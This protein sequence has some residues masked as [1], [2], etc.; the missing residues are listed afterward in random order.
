MN[1]AEHPLAF[2]CHGDTLYGILTMPEQQA[3]RAVLIVVG[4]PQYRTGS[5]RQFVL[6]AREFASHGYPVLRFDYR[7]M[8]DSEGAPRNFEQVDE[9]IRA[10]I[11]HLFES[12]PSVR[13][14]VI[15]GLCDGASAAMFYA[16]KDARVSGL[17]LVN[18]W[19]YT[20][21][22]EAKARL[23]HYYQARMLD[24]ELWKKIARGEF[25]FGA[26][27]KSL[28]TSAG[29]ACKHIPAENDG[30]ASSRLPDRLYVAMRRF[31]GETLLL[32]SEKDLTAQEFC[33]LL[34]QSPG[35]RD[36]SARPQLL[37]HNL[38][39]ANHTFSRSGWRDE[40]AGCILRWLGT[41]PQRRPAP[42]RTRMPDR[43]VHL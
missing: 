40:V 38:A 25:N 26:A 28:W 23:K 21:E 43:Q 33:A 11:D 1:Y 24:A 19:A 8:G 7:G 39:G 6:L 12:V 16:H 2:S 34:R 20:E 9:D 18:P 15:F 29:R 13:D 30:G 37:R 31:Q 5:H 14:V 10:A 17:A 36:L 42:S 32:L 41:A 22:G 3:S 4:G 27:A 35:W